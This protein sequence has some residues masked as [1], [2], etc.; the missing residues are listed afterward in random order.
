MK[1]HTLRNYGVVFILAFL[2]YFLSSG[3][4]SSWYSFTPQ[5]IY[6]AYSFLHAKL[7]LVVVPP[8][9]YDLILYNGYWFV[10]GAVAPALVLLPLVAIWG[11][12]VSDILFGIVVGAINV[13]AI[14]DLLG[15]LKPQAGF[16]H[17]VHANTR[18]WLTL[19]FAAGT[20]HWYIASMGSVWFNAQ[21]L[22]VTFMILFLRE[23]LTA[24]R[25]WLAGIWLSL[26]TLSRPPML[27][28]A[29]FYL[30]YVVLQTRDRRQALYKLVPFGVICGAT[31][32]ALLLYNDLRFH[33]PL[34]FGYQYVQGSRA[35]VTAFAKY[36]GFNTHF[37]PCNFYVSMFGMPDFKGQMAPGFTL[38]C[39]H[40]LSVHHFTGDT[41]V[42]VNPIGMS[43]FFVTPAFVYAF[44]ASLR[45]PLL[46]ASWIGIIAVLIPLWMYHNTGST[47]YGYRYIL[48][49]VVFIVILV[50]A[51]MQGRINR[52]EKLII[53]ASVLSNLVGMI[54]MANQ[55]MVLVFWINSI[56]TFLGFGG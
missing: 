54:W 21:V 52:L 47:Q 34:D 37:F 14:Y 36:G 51:G 28:A 50:A 55:G 15:K 56:R 49:V 48:D 39:R 42:A 38:F 46:L 20:A 16:S 29:G 12:N 27:F 26:A 45:K 17:E 40:L 33:N 23:T 18:N 41:L 7:H 1:A 32:G 31:V 10:P 13:L 11:L 8:D 5:Y 35:I 6:L 44:K 24:D 30:I 19:L 53:G 4:P 9:T 3:P 22:G 2:L 25:G 43:I